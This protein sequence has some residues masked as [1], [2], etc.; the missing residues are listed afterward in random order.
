MPRYF[1]EVSDGKV[2]Y[3]DEDGMRFPDRDTACDAGRRLAAELALDLPELHGF[4]VVIS[5]EKG[6]LVHSVAVS[7]PIGKFQ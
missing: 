4:A 2:M 6:E 1:F 7:P 3:T 5:D